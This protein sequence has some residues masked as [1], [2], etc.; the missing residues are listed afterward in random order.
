MTHDLKA[1]IFDLDGVL[2]NTVDL[3][4]QAWRELFDE[5]GIAF[6]RSDMNRFRGIHQRSI[7]LAVAGDLPEAQITRCLTRKDVLYRRSLRAAAE[8]ILQ[9]P[10]VEVLHAAKARGLKIGLASSSINAHYV[11][12]MVG[13]HDHFDVIAD[14][15]TVCRS[16]PAPD[17]FVWVAGALR[18]S[19]RE[20]AVIE[21]G[22]AGVEAAL[23]AGMFVVG[24]DVDDTDHP[25]HFNR[26]LDSIRF[27]EI[28]ER[29]QA[30]EPTP[31]RQAGAASVE[32]DLVLSG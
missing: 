2:V 9:R 13:L 10:L 12:E 18:L 23:V 25:P 21:D 15:S 24:I 29:Y 32:L 14:G 5:L 11:L 3:H 7:L 17:I 1:M 26:A 19:P 16:K 20:I 22:R 30:W 8:T 31:P 28:A 4:Y 6:S 27:E